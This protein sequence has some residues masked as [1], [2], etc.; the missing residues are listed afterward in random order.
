MPANAAELDREAMPPGL[1]SKANMYHPWQG[2]WREGRMA[3][4]LQLRLA[5][6]HARDERTER[7]AREGSVSR[8]V[9]DIKL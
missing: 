7:R 3:S 6:I 5:L 8:G 1:R 4:R 2:I 9:S